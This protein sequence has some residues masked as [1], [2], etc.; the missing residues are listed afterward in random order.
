[1]IKAIG[2]A[3]FVVFAGA[4]IT[5]FEPAQVLKGEQCFIAFDG[6]GDNV[7]VCDTQFHKVYTNSKNGNVNMAFRGQLPEGSV[8]PDKTVHFFTGHN[9]LICSGMAPNYKYTLTPSGQWSEQCR[10]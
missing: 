2:M 5:S 10:S 3:L 6:N 7:T 9:G 1:M 4:E 8:L